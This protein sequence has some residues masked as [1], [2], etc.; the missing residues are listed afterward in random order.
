MAWLLRDGQVLASI[1]VAASFSARLKGPMGRSALEGGLL[2]PNMK[3]THSIG[4]RLGLDV[5]WLG[6]DDVVMAVSRVRPFSLTL[7]RLRARSVLLAEAGAFS[8]WGL[9]IGDVLELKE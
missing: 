7:P 2:L 9:A 4:T 6:Q 1:E 8:R 5:A 3:A